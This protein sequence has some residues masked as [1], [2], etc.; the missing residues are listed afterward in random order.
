MSNKPGSRLKVTPRLDVT[1]EGGG[2]GL[3]LQLD[4]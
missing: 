1:P 2:G 3:N 4:F